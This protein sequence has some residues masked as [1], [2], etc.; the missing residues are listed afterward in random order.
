MYRFPSVTPRRRR[1]RHV[2][3]GRRS[4]IRDPQG[5]FEQSTGTDG[6]TDGIPYHADFRPVLLPP[7]FHLTSTM[8]ESA[9][10]L[11]FLLFRRRRRPRDGRGTNESLFS[12]TSNSYPPFGPPFTIFTGLV[13]LDLGSGRQHRWPGGGP[14][15]TFTIYIYVIATLRGRRCSWTDEV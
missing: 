15:T 1:R 11:L 9:T 7:F 2:I 5:K 12:R 3:K 14:T 6:R 10:P 4:R 13:R 8:T